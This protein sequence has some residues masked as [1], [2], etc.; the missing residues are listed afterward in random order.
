ML[1][2]LRDDTKNDCAPQFWAAKMLQHTPHL[3]LINDKAAQRPKH[4]M[5]LSLTWRGGGEGEG[6]GEGG[7]EGSG[8]VRNVPSILFKIVAQL[9]C[10][11]TKLS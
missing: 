3:P 5:F 11:V 9:H 1:L 7:G 10:R 4:P 6:R 2:A 8:R